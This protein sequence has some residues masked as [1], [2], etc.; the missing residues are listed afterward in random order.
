MLRTTMLSLTTTTAGPVSPTTT[1]SPGH[2]RCPSDQ[3]ASTHV[4]LS[5]VETA[6]QRKADVNELS[7]ESRNDT[8]GKTV[9]FE[10]FL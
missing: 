5:L 7:E 10:A 2:G 4:P 8:A 9:A 1:K 3:L 6:G